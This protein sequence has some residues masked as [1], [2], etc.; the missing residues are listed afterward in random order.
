M[1]SGGGFPTLPTI[2]QALEPLIITDS[3]DLNNLGSL[4]SIGK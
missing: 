3:F 1:F 2:P 4:F